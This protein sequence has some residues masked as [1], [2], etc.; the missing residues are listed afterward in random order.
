MKKIGA[1]ILSIVIGSSLLVGCGGK[2]DVDKS[3][4]DKKTNQTQTQTTD[5]RNTSTTSNSTSNSGA[6]NSTVNNGS[7]TASGQAVISQLQKE[8]K[9]IWDSHQSITEED[10][11]KYPMLA[12]EK[13]LFATYGEKYEVPGDFGKSDVQII[14]DTTISYNCYLAPKD[15]SDSIWRKVTMKSTNGK[16]KE[17]S[18]EASSRIKK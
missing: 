7:T 9:Q 10:E 3:T 1:L 8:E 17:I 12:L 5:N 13:Y 11:K 18:D 4:D 6:T 14:D 15:G 16:W 2:K